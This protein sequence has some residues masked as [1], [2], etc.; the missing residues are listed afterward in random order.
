M[1]GMLENVLLDMG[2]SDF[3]TEILSKIILIVAVVLL[4]IIADLLAKKILLSIINKIVEKTKTK[5][6]DILVERGLFNRLA[7]I[8]PVLGL[9]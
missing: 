7:N 1:I 5:W 9:H 8:V 4:S 6:D 2:L 3:Y